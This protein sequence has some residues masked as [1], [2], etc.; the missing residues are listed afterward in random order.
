[1]DLKSKKESSGV[2][3]LLVR[4]GETDWN[5]AG[6][7][8]GRSD[9]PLNQKGVEQANALAS[10]LRKESLAAIYSSPLVRAKET[11]RLIKVFH[12]SSPL[13]EDEG[14][15]EMDLGEFEGIEGPRW[16]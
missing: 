14:L 1:M 8:Q 12:P 6:R 4:H 10:A 16:A 7:F 2:K 13:F 5:L 3:I 9:V 11:A 15:V